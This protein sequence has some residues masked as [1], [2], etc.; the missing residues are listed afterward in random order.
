MF[1]AESPTTE[2]GPQT[3]QLSQWPLPPVHISGSGTPNTSLCYHHAVF[4]HTRSL[5]RY[6]SLPGEI[7]LFLYWVNSHSSVK[8]LLKCHFLHETIT[9]SFRNIIPLSAPLCSDVEY[10]TLHFDSLFEYLD[11]LFAYHANASW[12]SSIKLNFILF[13]APSLYP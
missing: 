2:Q 5:C 3:L 7:L 10:S 8:I 6:K 13:I 11:Y 12:A 1:T 9:G 4:L